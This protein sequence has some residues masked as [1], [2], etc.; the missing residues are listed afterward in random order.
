MSIKLSDLKKNKIRREIV[1]TNK[2]G[3]K[4]VIIV[5]NPYDD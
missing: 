4:E 2:Q 5:K 1:F 3:E